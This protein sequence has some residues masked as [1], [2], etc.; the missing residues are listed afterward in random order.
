MKGQWEVDSNEDDTGIV[1]TFAHMGEDGVESFVTAMPPEC[2]LEF[3]EALSSKAR[4]LLRV[5]THLPMRSNPHR[6][7]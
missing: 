4:E 5:T 7:S 2:A 6:E 1:L 3:G